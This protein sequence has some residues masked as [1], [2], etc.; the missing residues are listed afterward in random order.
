MDSNLIKI[1]LKKEDR[2]YE[3]TLESGDIH[4]VFDSMFTGMKVMGFTNEEIKDAM[5]QRFLHVLINSN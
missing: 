1:H 2:E 5:K 3:H 4:E